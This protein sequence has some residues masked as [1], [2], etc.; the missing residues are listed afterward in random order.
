V[1]AAPGVNVADL[2]QLH[3]EKLRPGMVRL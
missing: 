2:R 1:V 3:Y